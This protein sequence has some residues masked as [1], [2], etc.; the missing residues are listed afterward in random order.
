M[1]KSVLCETNGAFMGN[2]LSMLETLKDTSNLSSG[3]SKQYTDT[4]NFGSKDLILY[5]LGS[6]FYKKKNY[7]IF[8]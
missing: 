8:D 6:E 7:I 1:S 4:F 3:T 2:L 5:A